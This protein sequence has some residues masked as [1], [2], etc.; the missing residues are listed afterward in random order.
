MEILISHG[1]R[2]GPDYGDPTTYL[3]LL[4]DGNA[5]NYGK[6]YS[7]EYE[8]IMAKVSTESDTTKRGNI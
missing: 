5:N 3:N 8:E 6:Y 7:K 1:T 4:L 2:W